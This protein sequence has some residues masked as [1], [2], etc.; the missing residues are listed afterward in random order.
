MIKKVY[1][2]TKSGLYHRTQEHIMGIQKMC[3]IL[4][5]ECILVVNDTSLK[6]ILRNGLRNGSISNS[7]LIFIRYENIRGGKI[8]ILLK[9]NKNITCYLNTEQMC[10]TAS[11]NNLLG[12]IRNNY[13]DMILDYSYKNLGQIEDIK[14]KKNI[15][16]FY[17]YNKNLLDTKLQIKQSYDVLFTGR[18]QGQRSIIFEELKKRGLKVCLLKGF[19]NKKWNMMLKTKCIVDAIHSDYLNNPNPHRC[20]P[21]IYY[22]CFVFSTL[23]FDENKSDKNLYYKFVN[24]ENMETIVDKIVETCK[25]YNTLINPYINNIKNDIEKINNY[26]I[27]EFKKMLEIK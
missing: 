3:E 15:L 25:N 26:G 4:N 10:N 12:H 14:M 8:R 7:F 22:G 17:F 24:L 5:I 23:P 19:N 16:P 2:F 27:S 6:S 21:G 20:I 18:H 13:F 1:I 9:R 11:K